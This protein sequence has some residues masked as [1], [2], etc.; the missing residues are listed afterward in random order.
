ML[1]KGFLI[2]TQMI[3]L[4]GAIEFDFDYQINFEL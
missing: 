4:F 3:Q 2:D 1:Q